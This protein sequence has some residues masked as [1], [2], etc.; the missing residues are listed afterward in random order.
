M[1]DWKGPPRGERTLP[2][3]FLARRTVGNAI[4]LL[5]IVAFRASPVWVLAALA[6][7]AA[8]GR[9]LI[10]E[11][12][13]ALKAQ[14]LLEK[15]TQFSTVNQLLDGLEQTSSRLA[16]TLTRRRSTSQAS[17][18]EWEAI[19]Q[20]ARRLAAGPIPS[21]ETIR[22][23]WSQ[24]RTE[25]KHQG[26]SIFETSSADGGLSRARGSSG[27]RTLAP[28]RPPESARHGTSRSLQLHYSITT[29]ETLSASRQVGYLTYAGR[30]LGPYI[31]ASLHQFS[32]KQ[33]TITERLIEKLSRGEAAAE[34]R[35][36][37]D[38]PPGR[39]LTARW[40]RW[41]GR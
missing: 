17:A 29:A 41:R 5:G 21:R 35:T 32:P 16:A 11:I 4:E 38:R 12:A 37:A 36:P 7:A 28:P 27:W 6:D 25:S 15:G 2:D 14:G 8:F 24:L 30:Q 23:L 19:R 22:N 39:G 13:D 26:R 18:C 31:R 3:D 10:P 9:H 1:A 33:R 34:A 40:S 20:D